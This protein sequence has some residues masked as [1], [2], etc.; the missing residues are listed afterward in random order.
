MEVR[1]SC[2]L[3]STKDGS[4]RTFGGIFK[5]TCLKFEL[6]IKVCYIPAV[7]QVT[8]S[9]HLVFSLF[10][11]HT[12]H[13]NRIHDNLLINKFVNF[14]KSVEVCDNSKFLINDLN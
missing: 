8:V 10:F 9:L 11:P 1:L 2:L 12:R 3:N 4:F 14:I 5:E 6:E 7:V 13:S